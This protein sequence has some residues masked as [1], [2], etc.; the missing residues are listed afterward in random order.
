MP[1][2]GVGQ[3]HG[4]WE[5]LAQHVGIA[6]WNHIVEDAVDDQARLR[7]LA[8]PVETLATPLFP[9]SKGRDLSNLIV[10]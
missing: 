3:Q 1:S 8:E 2:V 7:D 6:D 10:K 9:S 5:M 4:V